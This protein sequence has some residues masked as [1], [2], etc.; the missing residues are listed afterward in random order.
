MPAPRPDFEVCEQTQLALARLSLLQEGE[1]C[2]WS[3]LSAAMGCN[4]QEEGR[5]NVRS[6]QDILER[7]EGKVLYC[8]RTVGIK[9]LTDPEVSRL[10]RVGARKA[11]RA[12]RRYKRKLRCLRNYDSLTREQQSAYLAGLSMLADLE[13]ASNH[14]KV[15]RKEKE[16]LQE[17]LQN[18]I[19]PTPDFAA[20]GRS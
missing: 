16:K 7:E 19:P 8:I 5:H 4:A 13:L 10:G 15:L 3:S 2:T 20:L 11:Y 17:V 1:T 9:W 18:A 12:V 14:H 6:A